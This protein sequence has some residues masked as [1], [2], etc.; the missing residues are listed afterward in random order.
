M[1]EELSTYELLHGG[2]AIRCKRC[3]RVSF[4]WKDIAYAF[5]GCCQVFHED[6]PQ[7]LRQWW[8]DHPEEK[9]R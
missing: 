3:G 1:S 8:L 5:C 9:K 4:H 2:R 7:E 6:I